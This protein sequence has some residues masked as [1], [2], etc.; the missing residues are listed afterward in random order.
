MGLA[1]RE[2]RGR[3]GSGAAP[4][5][6]GRAPGPAGPR[7][8]RLSPWEGCCR[9]LGSAHAAARLELRGLGGPRAHHVAGFCPRRWAHLARA[10]APATPLPGRGPGRPSHGP[11]ERHLQAFVQSRVSAHSFVHSLTLR[12][13]LLVLFSEATFSQGLFRD[14]PAQGR[15]L[16][17]CLVGAPTQR[18]L[19][20]A[21]SAGFLQLSA[22]PQR[23]SDALT[24]F[25]LPHT[26]ETLFY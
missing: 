4:G 16:R 17:D 12:S 5:G 18:R 19:Q 11:R 8:R 3:G 15:A 10:P 26:S 20:A 14:E 21:R 23:V 6:T 2:Q 13:L 1:W 24:L 22:S 7:T 25:K 9:C